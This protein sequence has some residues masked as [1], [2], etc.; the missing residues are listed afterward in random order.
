[1]RGFAYMTATVCLVIG[2]GVG[3]LVGTKRAA[4]PAS[5]GGVTG[6]VT[7]A[8]TSSVVAD[9]LVGDG[10]VTTSYLPPRFHLREGDPNDVGLGQS[11]RPLNYRSPNPWQQLTIG[12]R[13]ASEPLGWHTINESN[14]KYKRTPVEINGHAGLLLTSS[15]S[16]PTVEVDWRV[17][18]ATSISVTGYLLTSAQVEA[19]ARGVTFHPPT[20]VALPFTPGAIVSKSEAI[21]AA[22]ASGHVIGAKLSS[23]TEVATLAQSGNP[24][25]SDNGQADAVTIDVDQDGRPVIT[26][27]GAPNG[28]IDEPWK[29]VWAVL[30]A[31][32]TVVIVD[33]ANGKTIWSF[34]DGPNTEWFRGITD[35]EPGQA[36]C[37]GG[38]RARIPFGVLTLDEVDY[39]ASSAA[40]GLTVPGATSTTYYK[41]VSVPALNK[42][43][44]GEGCLQYCT[45]GTVEWIR[46]S[47][48]IAKPG[49]K[50]I[51]PIPEGPQGGASHPKET[52]EY[53]EFGYGD[54]GGINCGPPQPWYTN[55]KN[56][57]PAARARRP[58]RVT[59]DPLEHKTLGRSREDNCE[60][61]L[62][63][64]PRG[65]SLRLAWDKWDTTTHG[66]G[67]RQR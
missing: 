54:G 30:L 26:A 34:S 38:T 22:S 14:Y 13:P 50:V 63:L 8:C 2:I 59:G 41:L 55:L 58:G 31:S 19:V 60:V 39:R 28:L 20:V 6:F 7:E 40:G 23:F 52:T 45:L 10:A 16:N 64:G 11:G 9:A 48:T 29:P 24:Q 42:Q 56:L 46:M 3:L 35:R 21:R 51:C 27:P 61:T 5:R 57:A 33:A 66:A 1:M 67:G 49:T 17:T 43:N 32:G 4:L 44:T 62:D 37:L 15:R 65:P 25:T 18:G 36:G 53:S 47:V 12:P